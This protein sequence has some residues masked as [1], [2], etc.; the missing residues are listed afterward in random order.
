MSP[1]LI[2]LVISVAQ[3]LGM[4]AAFFGLYN[5]AHTGM[6]HGEDMKWSN[7]LFQILGGAL[8]FIFCWAILTV[9]G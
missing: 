6:N 9:E 3:A 7:V 2:I 5:L 1:E 4:T 8:L